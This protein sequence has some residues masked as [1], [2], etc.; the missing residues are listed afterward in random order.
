MK[1][2]SVSLAILVILAVLT[3]IVVWQYHMIPN[4]NNVGYSL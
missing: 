4:V 2:V 3:L 1:K